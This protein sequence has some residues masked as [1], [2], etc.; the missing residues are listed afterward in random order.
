MLTESH[1]DLLYF[2]SGF[3]QDDLQELF[4]RIRC[5][6]KTKPHA[7]LRDF[8]EHATCIL[9]E[10]FRRLPGSLRTVLP[11]LSNALDLA[12]LSIPQRGPLAGAVEGVLSCLLYIASLIG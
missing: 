12:E 9:H 8:L 4:R 10:E 7:I 5:Q 1:F 6:S 2:P 11:P 3:P